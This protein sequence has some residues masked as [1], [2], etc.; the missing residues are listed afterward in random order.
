MVDISDDEILRTWLRALDRGNVRR[1]SAL[2]ADP[3]ETEEDDSPMSRDAFL[4]T[5]GG[6]AKACP[7]WGV[8][9]SGV[10]AEEGHLVAEVT[11]HG[12]QAEPLD[13]TRAGL[14]WIPASGE[15]FEVQ[16]T[17]AFSLEDGRVTRD[18]GSAGLARVLSELGIG[19]RR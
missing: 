16:D 5:V 15:R 14:G 17:V 11:V 13:L 4:E 10:H 18:D 7:D 19:P 9:V 6:L 2:T 1:L 8:D 12:T 3:H